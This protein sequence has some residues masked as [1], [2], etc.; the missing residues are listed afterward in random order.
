M[1]AS[2]HKK[3]IK[4]LWAHPR[5]RC[6]FRGKLGLWRCLAFLRAGV[7]ISIV[8]EWE[9]GRVLAN[10][11]FGEDARDDVVLK[12]DDCSI[13]ILPYRTLLPKG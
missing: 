8:F 10:I 9:L 11:A 12:F 5:G 13:G 4:P 1:T 7:V 2:N 6:P 3:T